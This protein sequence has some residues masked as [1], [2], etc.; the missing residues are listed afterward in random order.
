MKAPLKT[1]LVILGVIVYSCNDKKVQNKEITSNIYDTLES[2]SPEPEYLN[3]QKKYILLSI[4]N[5]N[6]QDINPVFLEL[7]RDKKI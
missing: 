4:T 7:L 1:V 3:D 2:P 6:V 5:I